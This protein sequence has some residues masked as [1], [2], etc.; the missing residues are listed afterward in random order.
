MI[1]TGMKNPPFE[2]FFTRYTCRKNPEIPTPVSQK[3]GFS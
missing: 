1:T 3:S 2:K